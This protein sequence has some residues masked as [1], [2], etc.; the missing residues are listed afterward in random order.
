MSST[1]IS[2][3]LRLH[4]RFLRSVHLE[5]DLADPKSS[6]GY[7]A[8]PVAEQALRRV[9]ASAESNSTQRAWRVA[10]DYGAGKSGFGLLLARLA[11]GAKGELPPGLRHLAPYHTLM[12]A[13]ATGDQES[14]GRTVL[15]AL[16]QRWTGNSEPST[17]DVLSAVH[18]GVSKARKK[19][20]TGLLLI[21]DE[22]GKNLEFAARNPELDDV[23][24][25]QRLAEEAARSGERPFVIVVM[26][27]QGIAAYSAGLNAAAKREWAKVAGRYE[28]IIYAQPLE[29]IAA[30]VAATLNVDTGR[31][32]AALRRESHTAMK[33]AIHAGLYGG[34]AP[35]TLVDLGPQLFPLHPSVLPVLT[36]CMRRFGQNERSLFSF[37]S[38][39]EVHGLQQHTRNPV[40]EGHYR[41]SHLFDYLRSSLLPS[42][43][44]GSAHTHWGVIDS[45]L[46][47]TRTT[48]VEEENVLKTVALLSLLDAPDLPA[49]EGVLLSAVAGERS[50]VAQ[51]LRSLRTQGVLY[52]R[53]SSKAHCL[54]PHTSVNLT[55]IFERAC[56]F[57]GGTSGV[58]KL[59][60]HV[61]SEQLA[62]RSYY[63]RTGTLRYAEVKLL[64]ASELDTLL[65]QPPIITGNGA[66]LNVRVLLPKDRSEERM[67][68]ERLAA[69]STLPEGLY[70]AV[71]APPTRA[72]SALDDV[73][74]WRWV[75]ENTPALSGDR[76]A[77]EEVA[78]QLLQA[79]HNLQL[80][81]GGLENLGIPNGE[82]M[83]WHYR[84]SRRELANGRDLLTFL[85]HECLKIYSE[86]PH[87]LNEL[88][89][90][91][92]PSSAAVGARSKL[93]EAMATAPDQ[94]NLGMD[95]TKRPAEM[96]LYLS[97]L[98]AGG[99][100]HDTGAEWQFRLPEPKEDRCNLLPALNHITNVLTARGVD[101]LIPLPEVL[102]SL[103]LPPFG[104]REGLQPFVLAIYLATHH[105]RVALYEDG[106]YRHNVG[107]D[108][109]LRMG[110]E[111]QFFQLQYCQLEGVRTEV[112]SK[113]LRALEI[114]PRDAE[115]TDLL[116]LVRPLVVFI[117]REVPEYSRRTKHL[118]ASAV[119]VRAA[120]LD[121]REPVSLVFTRL[122]QAC[123]LEPIQNQSRAKAE[124]LGGRLKAALHEIRNAYAGL[125][126][127]IR[128]AIYAAFK[129]DGGQVQERPAISAR[130]TQLAAALTEPGLRAFA[131]RL[132][133]TSLEERAWTESVANL[134]A[135][136]SPER[137]L[138]ADETEFCHQLE[139]LA[140]RFKRTEF[141]LIGTTQKLNGHAVR[142]AMTKSDGSEVGELVD[143]NSM[144]ETKLET[145]A[146][147]FR[148]FLAA[149]G[150]YGKAA[151]LKTMWTELDLQ[152]PEAP[153]ER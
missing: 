72:V 98:K 136:K 75:K 120:L 39:A 29:Q 43:V 144:D 13:V 128:T 149:H 52:E 2:S 108:A 42:I 135:R 15:R 36:R 34:A 40:A 45:V 60:G 152:T 112:F 20:H 132:A 48:T 86:G 57:T 110:K 121:G 114:T 94:P 63:A 105:Q 14:L 23:F 54:W 65:A 142:F 22:L 107:G 25:L 99:F 74:A 83:E 116:D 124:E 80:R 92:S 49:T 115:Q 111:P 16:G 148:E 89:N 81:L 31:L 78:R 133:D 134:L 12:P 53:G 27:H 18:D 126:T 61:H 104:I 84:R 76:F 87:V 4:P 44:G 145:V 21:V 138:D 119:A 33:E 56:E 35:E 139:I 127:R 6:L 37:L 153:K 58:Q 19:Y 77:R 51:A 70:V 71:G 88:I 7:V 24:L 102:A 50:R 5:G 113:L 3:L 141:A 28:E 73:L 97:V 109:F 137:W 10:G 151:A 47:S 101:A 26:L 41:L 123:G 122:P 117:S 125:L 55:E 150:R 103:S 82:T 69:K 100:H 96:A 9:L 95:D 17:E 147:Q 64:P 93:V 118:S 68:R 67:A 66:D 90:R 38:S 79:E 91:R 30:L 32:P 46:A 129:V 106:T 131:L 1:K 85:G 130:A 140:G 62:P 8:T 146:A 143:W 59:C 11:K